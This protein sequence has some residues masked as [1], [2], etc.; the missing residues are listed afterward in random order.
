MDVEQLMHKL[1]GLLGD[2]GVDSPGAAESPYIAL[3]LDSVVSTLNVMRA[4]VLTVSAG[5]SRTTVDSMLREH[6]LGRMQREAAFM[7]RLAEQPVHELEATL[8]ARTHNPRKARPRP[9]ARAP[10]EH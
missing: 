5:A 9:G 2:L 1:R 3:A 7:V 8:Q 10:S 4:S 6:L